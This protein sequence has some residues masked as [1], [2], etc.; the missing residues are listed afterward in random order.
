M[1]VTYA[2]LLVHK[3][4]DGLAQLRERLAVWGLELPLARHPELGEL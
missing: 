1:E 2:G 3:L 4:G